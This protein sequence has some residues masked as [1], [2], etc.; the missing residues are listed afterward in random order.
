MPMGNA[1]GKFSLK[2][3]SINYSPTGGGT[4]IIDMNMEGTMEG[5]DGA[6]TVLGTLTGE[7]NEDASGGN[8][9]WIGREF[10][11]DGSTR[12]ATGSGFFRATGAGKWAL[13]GTISF[14]DGANAAVEGDLDLASRT[15]SG[16]ACE[17]D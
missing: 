13:R 3:T 1:L 8:Y 4:E 5:P 7:P 10:A 2:S 6:A 12:V 11:A 15:L 9:N 14:S 17:W 16:T